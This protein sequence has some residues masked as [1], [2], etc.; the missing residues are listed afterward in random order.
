MKERPGYK[1]SQD[2]QS[3]LLLTRLFSTLCSLSCCLLGPT[4]HIVGKLVKK[5]FEAAR[6]LK[7]K[8]YKKKCLCLTRKVAGLSMPE[9]NTF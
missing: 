3:P 2:Y 1:L 6:R 9:A 4:Q 5:K 8:F 7:W